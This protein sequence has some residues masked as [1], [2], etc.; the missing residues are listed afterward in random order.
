MFKVILA[1]FQR[2]VL[3]RPKSSKQPGWSSLSLSSSLAPGPAGHAILAPV[4]CQPPALSSQGGLWEGSW[5]HWT[6]GPGRQFPPVPCVFT[7]RPRGLVWNKHTST[8]PA[9][10]IPAPSLHRLIFQ[11]PDLRYRHEFDSVTQESAHRGA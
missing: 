5:P 8:R 6:S 7:P 10:R 3:K 4:L 11:P 1:R 2:V 9:R